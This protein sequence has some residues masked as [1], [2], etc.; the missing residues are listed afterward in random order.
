MYETGNGSVRGARRLRERRR[1]HR[2]HRA[3]VPGVA[4][5]RCIEQ[6]AAQMRAKKLPMVEDI[7]DESDHENPIA[8]RASMPRSNRVDVDAADGAPVRDHRPRAQLSRQPQRDR[9]RRQAAGEGPASDL[10]AEWLRVPQ[11]H[12]HAPPAATASTR[13]TR[14]C[15]SSKA[16]CVA[17]LNLDEV[18][19]IIRREDEPKPVLMK[20]FKLSEDQAD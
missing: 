13:S 15:T 7:R 6:I 11:R 14:A 12:G 16:C 1:Q 19:R 17:Y 20:R 2:H 18:I 8:H 4:A 9:P 3:A 10:L 5:A